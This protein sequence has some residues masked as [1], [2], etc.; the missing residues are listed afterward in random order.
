MNISLTPE[1]EEFVDSLLASGMY[2]SASEVVRAGLRHLRRAEELH[3]GRLHELR[4]LVAEGVADLEYG[5]SFAFDADDIKKK[6]R[7]R[8]P[9]K[10]GHTG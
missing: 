5:R 10:R 9:R 3:V 8:R 1:L 7:K 6:A 4:S 2:S